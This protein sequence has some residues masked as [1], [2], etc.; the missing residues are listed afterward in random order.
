MVEDYPATLMEFQVPFPTGE[1]R[2]DYLARLRL[3]NG[4]DLGL[5]RT[6]SPVTSLIKLT[7]EET[8]ILQAS[9]ERRHLWQARN[10]KTALPE[11]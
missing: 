8:F 7:L 9:H 4:L 5:V 10:V 1:A 3:A 6:A 11:R 2:R